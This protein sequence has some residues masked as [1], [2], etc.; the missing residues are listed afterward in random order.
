DGSTDSTSRVAKATLPQAR[1]LRHK[2]NRGKGYS[3]RKGM[4]AASN[5]MVLFTDSDLS[6]PFD[7]VKRMIPLLKRYDLVIA[8]RNLPSSKIVVPQPKLRSLAGKALPFLVQALLIQGIKDTQC[9]FKLFR[10]D[11]ARAVFPLTTIDRFGF[12]MEVIFLAHKLGYRVKETSVRW[13]N[14]GGSKVRLFP[15]AFMMF[16]DIFRIHINNLS[17][18]Y[19]EKKP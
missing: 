3:V 13:F 11:C 16:V 9:G 4:M 14:S 2:K 8:S 17:G 7:E 1:V 19:D 12:D 18:S 5:D 15:D 10:R 6:T